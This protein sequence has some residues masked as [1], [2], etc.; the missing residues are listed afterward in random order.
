MKLRT[1]PC[2]AAPGSAPEVQELRIR[3]RSLSMAQ[4]ESGSPRRPM[5]AGRRGRRL[6]DWLFFFTSCLRQTENCGNPF[7]TLKLCG[8]D[9]DGCR[10]PCRHAAHRNPQNSL[11]PH[12]NLVPAVLHFLAPP[13]PS[14]RLP[15]S[16]WRCFPCGSSS[17]DPTI[18]GGSASG[19][20]APAVLHH[21]ILPEAS[22]HGM[23]KR[24]HGM[25][26]ALAFVLCL[27]P[28]ARPCP[29]LRS[30][31]ALSSPAS[32]TLSRRAR[33][34]AGSTRHNRSGR[35][36]SSC[37]RSNL[38]FPAKLRN[39]SEQSKRTGKRY[40]IQTCVSAA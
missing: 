2:E 23:L 37:W 26:R 8:P 9:V 16:S 31:P 27:A 12:A 40:I 35:R 20:L 18:R 30:E 32:P 21:P 22:K 7:W 17:A 33:N 24:P 34:P 38:P 39:P 28:R 15:G 14:P 10:Y 3:S 19:A 36:R 6:M 13:C 4:T 5:R 1:G 11:L 25:P 29:S